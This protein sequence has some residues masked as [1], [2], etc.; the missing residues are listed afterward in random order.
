[1][2]TNWAGNYTYGARTVHR[3]TSIAQLQ[4]IVASTQRLRPVGS[5]HTFTAISDGVEQVSLDRMPVELSIDSAARTV[6]FG[7]QLS[8]GELAHELG[9]EGM[10]VANLASLPHISVPGAVATATHGSGDGNGNL[11]TS[12]AGLEIVTADGEILTA[13]RGDGDFDG[14]V[15]ALGALGVVS[16]LT[17]EVEPAY[18][19][20]QRVFE[21]LAWDALLEHFDE[22]TACGYSVS[23]FTLWAEPASRVWVKNRVSDAPE[24]MR[25]D[26]FGAAPAIGNRH[27]IAG[28]DPVN[29][30]PQLGDPGLW[31]ERL[32]HFR[33][34]F[35]PSSG[36]EIQ[37]EYFVPRR[38]AV[39]AIEAV[40]GLAESI[41][42]LLQVTEIR[43]IAADELWLSPQYH[44]D[45]V[46][47]HFTWRHDQTAVERML[48][49]VEAALAPF[50]PRPHWGKLFLADARTL[51]PRYPR[52]GDFAGVAARLDPHGKFTNEW[53]AR[54][55]LGDAQDR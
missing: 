35:T 18:E 50:D 39:P 25:G 4:E 49:E 6:S 40:R 20:R 23:V 53:L 7:G 27:V 14:M 46:G 33:M 52:L 28:Y 11:A 30:T 41:R 48:V 5:R 2:Q 9:R 3:P 32:P 24:A 15:V 21:G 43:S 16:R 44:E 31:S 38:H 8:Y 13:S 45:A 47:I 17:L 51:A 26:L 12:V 34:G 36:E 1:M 10:A 54:H 19:V 42:P 55:V 37:S 29:C 22:I